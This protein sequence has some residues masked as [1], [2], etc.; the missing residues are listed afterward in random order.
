[1]VEQQ[2]TVS[3]VL[4]SGGARGLAHVGAIR[5]LEDMGYQVQFVSGSSMGALVGGV[6]ATGQLQEYE[7]WSRALRR[8]DMMQLMDFGFWSGG[9]LLKGDRVMAALQEL[10]G[11]HQIEQLPIGYTAVATDLHRQ[12]EVWLKEGPLFDAIRASIAIPMIF[13]PVLRG[14]HLL[15]DGGVLNPLPIAPT[16]N[17]HTDITVAIDV[18][19]TDACLPENRQPVQEEHVPPAVDESPETKRLAVTNFFK[20]WFTQAEKSDKAEKISKGM[21]EIAMESMD[22]MQVSISRL[23]SSAYSPDVLVQLPGSIGQIFEFDRAAEFIEL[24]Y[25]ATEEALSR[26]NCD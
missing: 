2:K 9:G 15:V 24:G 10:I 12:R 8:S 6:Y 25:Q 3:L 17:H 13:T 5:C 14:A 20:Q 18:N 23:K 22:A 21:L 4:S 7:V 11:E 19:C 16:F 26:Q 1:M